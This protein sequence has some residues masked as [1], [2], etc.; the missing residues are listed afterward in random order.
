[1]ERMTVVRRDMLLIFLTLL[2]AY[3]YVLPRW[4][5]WSQNSRLNLV[6]ALV[7]Q[8]TTVI[9]AYVANTGDYALYNG[10]TYT[11]KPPGLSFVALPFYAAAFPIIEH[12]RVQP[13]LSKIAGGGALNSTL[14]E[15]GTGINSEKVRHF[16]AQALS[17]VVTVAFP[18]ALLGALLYAA[19]FQLGFGRPIRLLATFAYGLATPAAAYAG[20]FYSHQF[21]AALLFGAF[22][23][24]L[25]AKEPG[26]SAV[27]PSLAARASL[28][29][30]R[31]FL[32]GLLCSYALIS[33][34]PP[35]VIIA[36]FGVWALIRLRPTDLLLAAIGGLPPLLLMAFYN[37][38]AFGTI[39]PVGY[40]H[41]AL[42]QD[43]HHTGFMSITYPK[44]EA[45]WGLLF[46]SFRGLFSRAPWLL[47]AIP[48]FFIWWRNPVQRGLLGICLAATILLTLFYGSS[49]M[50]WGGYGVGPRYLVPMLP[51]LAIPAAYGV[52]FLWSS[53]GGKLLVV[54]L[55]AISSVLTWLETLAGQSFPNDASRNPWS[56]IVLP[57]WQAGNV[58]R[59]VGTALGLDG[60]L[61]MVPLAALLVIMIVA[62]VVLGQRPHQPKPP[63]HERSQIRT[64]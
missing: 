43:Q 49:V 4:A 42:W 14:N 12:P 7:E 60:A 17:T 50:W 33:E 31:A 8:R 29:A 53:R 32:F 62:T 28:G 56:D 21:V 39:W 48:G 22:F 37:L 15:S 25:H 6:R 34:Y 46:G 23:I 19:L 51:F 2:V 44:P 24:L 9:D 26:G 52:R 30:V 35:A 3:V 55:V 59:N 58:A 47:L 20:N 38:N 18:A 54:L 1:M 57:A 13:L 27:F 61:S 64:A 5:D 11:D 40:S 63:V 10:R 41:S 36:A 45:I 16:V